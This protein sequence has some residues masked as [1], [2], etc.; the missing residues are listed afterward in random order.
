MAEGVSRLD[1][2]FLLGAFGV[3]AVTFFTA[4]VVTQRA[5]HQIDVASDE[6]AFDSAPS[7]Q[8]LA[9]V[10]TA[11]RHVEF[12]V[13][14]ELMGVEGKRSHAEIEQALAQLTQEANA[15]LS[16]PTFPGEKDFWGD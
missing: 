12:L 5:M 7:I 3:V 16:L 4:N 9:A 13:G 1:L 6:I 2:R 14:A 15:Y 10:R 11:A 8:H